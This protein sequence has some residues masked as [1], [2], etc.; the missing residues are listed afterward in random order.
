MSEFDH[1]RRVAELR[2]QIL[3]DLGA[4]RR[5]FG[6]NIIRGVRTPFGEFGADSGRLLGS[7]SWVVGAVTGVIAG[8]IVSVL[9]RRSG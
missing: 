4:L 6:G 8:I 5:T 3:E 1:E 2:A 7:A 9:R